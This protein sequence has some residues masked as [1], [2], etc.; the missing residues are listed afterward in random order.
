[1]GEGDSRQLKYVKL[2]DALNQLDRIVEKLQFLGQEME[3]GSQFPSVKKEAVQPSAKLTFQGVYDAAPKRI[4][5]NV[6][7]VKKAIDDI[8]ARLF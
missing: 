8:R 7:K 4:E 5:S 2:N 6:E 3:E 1:M